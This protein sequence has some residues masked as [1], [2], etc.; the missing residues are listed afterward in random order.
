V[1]GSPFGEDNANTFSSGIISKINEKKGW[2]QHDA[3]INHGNSGGPLLNSQGQVIGI[4]TSLINPYGESYAG[5]SVALIVDYIQPFLTALLRDDSSLIAQTPQNPNDQPIV[6]NLPTNGQFITGRLQSS[7][8]V[9]FNGSHYQLYTFSVYAG[10][11]V[12]LEMNSNQIDPSL[13]ISLDGKSILAENDDISPTNF[14]SRL[15]V[16]LP[17]TG[18]YQVY[19]HAFERGETGEYQLRAFLQ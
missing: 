15:V 19:A 5:I 4:N 2:I 1:I 16:T 12:T 9:L 18:V 11:K 13:L 10:Q 14:N 7:D 6:H 8:Q 3:P 17:Q